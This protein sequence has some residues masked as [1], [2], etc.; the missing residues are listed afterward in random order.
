MIV[1]EQ[2]GLI[3]NGVGQ[4]GH[5]EALLF[6]LAARDAPG[7]GHRLEADA[8]HGV[9]VIDGD[10]HDV[11]HLVVVDALD[12]GRDEDD[13]DAGLAAGLDDPHLLLE[14][15][16]AARFAVNVVADAVKLQVDARQPGF[17][18]ALREIQIG[19]QDAVG[20][21]LDVGKAHLVRHGHD[22]DELRMN[23]RLAAGELHHAR[24][25][26]ALVAQRLQ[27]GVHLAELGLVQIAGRIG[28]GKADRAGQ[29]AAVGQIDIGQGGVRGV[30]RAHAAV[31]GADRFGALVDRGIGEPEVVAELPLLHLE[32]KLY[33]GVDA[34][35]EIAV[36][37]AGLF[38]HD[39]AILFKN[40]GVN[41]LPALWAQRLGRL[42][43]S[44]LLPDN[45]C[46]G[47][48]LGRLQ[49]LEF[50]PLGNGDNGGLQGGAHAHA[51]G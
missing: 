44:L 24:V 20:R 41:D 23:G 11:A 17:A 35:A 12:D 28:V 21:R 8:A 22:F 50:W 29:V 38:H 19:Q 42:G 46:A 40:E 13:L 27:H 49:D 26:R 18:A 47:K 10:A 32:V 25:H 48:G 31:V 36:L 1:V 43:Q 4:V 14:Q 16:F 30:Q 7:E 33:V 9:D 5:G 2:A 3:G 51:P 34:V 37:L 45:G 6:Q 39:P 15:G